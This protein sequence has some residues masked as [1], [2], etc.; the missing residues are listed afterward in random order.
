MVKVCK[1]NGGQNV[2]RTLQMRKLLILNLSTRST[3]GDLCYELELHDHAR[4][5]PF[6]VPVFVSGHGHI[7]T[8][9]SKQ[10]HYMS[11]ELWNMI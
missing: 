4:I 2:Q 7:H 9:R 1:A 10:I 5:L 6:H 11:P 3:S 8:K